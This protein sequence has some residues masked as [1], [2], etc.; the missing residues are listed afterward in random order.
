MYNHIICLD[1]L[2][3][4]GCGCNRILQIR[5]GKSN[6]GITCLQESFVN[7]TRLI[8][9]GVIFTLYG[10]AGHV[11]IQRHLG[12]SVE[13]P[14]KTD[15]RR[16]IS[17]RLVHLYRVAPAV[18]RHSSAGKAYSLQGLTAG[19][20]A[21]ITGQT[22]LCHL[23]CYT[24]FCNACCRKYRLQYR[25]GCLIRKSGRHKKCTYPSVLHHL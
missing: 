12:I 1:H 15:S 13:L 14:I 24:V 8:F 5:S 10:Y 4:P 19:L 20:Y 7:I 9:Q 25:S 2:N 11:F 18:I 6:S 23:I 16:Y 3:D 22:Y 17:I 21:K